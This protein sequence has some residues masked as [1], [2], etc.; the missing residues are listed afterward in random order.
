MIRSGS[1]ENL[2]GVGMGRGGQLVG[3]VMDDSLLHNAGLAKKR[4]DIL[5]R[6]GFKAG[7]YAPAQSLK[8]TV[9]C[10]PIL[11]SSPDMSSRDSISTLPLR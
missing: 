8:S 9:R 1:V 6:F 5:D 7:D 3:D 11:S 2:E 10:L 4:S